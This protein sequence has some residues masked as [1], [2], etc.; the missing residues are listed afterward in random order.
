MGV[1]SALALDLGQPAV[2]RATPA[3]VPALTRMLVRAYFDDP[4]AVWACAAEGLRSR[5]LERVYATRLRQMLAH[6]EVW[7]TPELT[8]AAVWVPPGRRKTTVR[9]QLA[10][11]RCVLHP[12]LLARVP[13][14]AVGLTGVER[15]HPSSPPHW[16][17]S[18]LATDP[19]AQGRGL[20]S[21]MLH[22]VLDRCD[23]HSVGTY[24]ETSK[25][26]NIEFYTRR[27]FHV[28]GELRLPRG[29]RMWLM[30]REPR[31]H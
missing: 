31:G 1:H 3:D 18:L 17:L 5:M 27:G 2:R 25:V 21:A 9:Q 13:L 7:T 15:R 22:P 23:N 8:S 24:L 28:T 10:L 29:P 20:G 19:D 26:R 11:A 6:E 14:L 16:Y 12:R 30:W 4:V